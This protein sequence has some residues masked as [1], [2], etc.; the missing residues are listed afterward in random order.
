M[1]NRIISFA[2]VLVMLFSCLSL[3]IFATVA[4]GT[5]ASTGITDNEEG[6]SASG[7]ADMTDKVIA[8]Y[9]E[10]LGTIGKSGGYNLTA[11]QIAAK[12]AK[13]DIVVNEDFAEWSAY[14][15]SKSSYSIP[16]TKKITL[17][18][19]KLF[20]RITPGESNG[21]YYLQWCK[22]KPVATKA[23]GSQFTDLTKGEDGKYQDAELQAR[24]DSGDVVVTDGVVYCKESPNG[25]YIQVSSITTSPSVDNVST[26]ERMGSAFTVSFDLYYTKGT[27]LYMNIEVYSK[28][29]KDFE[30]VKPIYKLKVTEDG[31]LHFNDGTTEDYVSTGYKLADDDCTQITITVTPRGIDG[32]RD[33][34]ASGNIIVG[35]D[36]NTLHLYANGKHLK[37]FTALKDSLVKIWTPKDSD[38]NALTDESGKPIIINSA[39]D[40]TPYWYRLGQS[41]YGFKLDDF[42]LYFGQ[43][44]EIA[45]AAHKNLAYSHKHDVKNNKNILTATCQD[46][47]CGVSETLTIDINSKQGEYGLSVEEVKALLA[48]EDRTLDAGVDFTGGAHGSLTFGNGTYKENDVDVIDWTVIADYTDKNGNDCLIWQRPVA[49]NPKTNA[50]FTKAEVEALSDTAKALIVFENGVPYYTGN[51]TSEFVQYT[52]TEGS[53]SSIKNTVKDPTNPVVGGA[54]VFTMDLTYYGGYFPFQV[55]SRTKN[56]SFE[57]VSLYPFKISDGKLYVINSSGKTEEEI[58]DVTIPIGKTFQITFLHTPR[59]FDGER[60]VENGYSTD[61]DNTFHIFI[62]GKLVVTRTLVPSSKAY[63]EWESTVDDVNVKVSPG[64]DFTINFVRIGQNNADVAHTTDLYTV[65]NIKVYRGTS[66]ECTHSFSKDPNKCDWCG[67]EFNIWKCELCDGNLISEDVIVVGQS[68]TLGDVIN[69]NAFLKLNKEPSLFGDDTVVLDTKE[70]GGTKRVEYKISDLAPIEEG[71]SLGLYK[72][73]IPLSSIDMARDIVISV[74]SKTDDTASYTARLSSYLDKLL[75]TNHSYYVRQLV[76]AMENYGAYAQKYFEGKNGN[77][78]DL[79]VL[80]NANLNE[81]DR[82]LIS[83]VTAETLAPYNVTITGDSVEVDYCTF[84]LDSVTELR[85][86]FRDAEGVT[87]SEN[88]KALTKHK[89]DDDGYSYVALTDPSPATFANEHTVVFSD[90]ESETT[91]TVSANSVLNLMY[92]SD[93][94]KMRNLAASMYLLGKA[95]YEYQ[96][97]YVLGNKPEKQKWDDDGVL[98]LLCLGNSFSVDAM[99]WIAEI[100]VDLGYKEIMFGNLYIGGCYID[101]HIKEIETNSTEY[102]YYLEIG[103]ADGVNKTKYS[104]HTAAEAIMSEN[105]DFISL[106]QGSAKS[107]AEQH[108][109]NL[110]TLIDY[111]KTVCPG[112]TLVWHQTWAYAEW[113]AN[114]TYSITQENMYKGI[115][116]CVQNCVMTNEDIEILVPSGTAIQNARTSYLGD[117]MN[118]DGTHLDYGVGRYIAALTFFAALT[119]EDISKVEWAPT[120]IGNDTADVDAAAR[121]VAIESV[122]NALKNPYEVTKSQYTVKPQ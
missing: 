23:D 72:V 66:V 18:N 47:G 67:H 11:A 88:G 87:A 117:N 95:S 107:Y 92:E 89:S 9:F 16:G 21:N 82:N 36:D 55:L 4:D 51:L 75:E 57:N 25:E 119:G 44:V 30:G 38:G 69:F 114:Q 31:I 50:L 116:N 86:F 14:N 12:V 19:N 83:T 108:Y 15:N 53:S 17:T 20:E 59:G 85:I 34:D 74:V 98:K 65:D 32:K 22:S 3:E 106:Q 76:K 42:R 93:N 113:Y 115:V 90:G 48:E 104:G 61:D 8:E 40:F 99:E 91:L 6:T 110:P 41:G 73:S 77:P 79:G 2:L 29:G 101:R 37:T 45:T 105:W 118:R 52:Y 33:V 70:S 63:K 46:E 54:Y 111:V 58:S 102:T 64:S 24:I 5:G 56:S 60:D 62:D 13:A 10:K 39:S 122:I 80:P 71:E 49:K 103:T 27:P 84:V 26:H 120:N 121:A 81:L 28:T 112:A 1:R 100:A 43:N 96:Q 94:E 78:D 97:Y 35:S 68:A 109:A 7:T